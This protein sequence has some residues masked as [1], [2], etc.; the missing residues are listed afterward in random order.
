VGEYA[1]TRNCGQGN[2][3]G[4]LGEAAFMTG[5]ERNSDVVI[6]ASYAPLFVNINYKKWNPDLIDFDGARVYG[7]PSYY[8][9]KMFSENR[10]DVV[11]PA[12]LEV[13]TA[14][15]EAPHGGIGLSTW[16]TQAEFKDMRVT[17]GDNTLFETK[18]GKGFEGWRAL[19]GDWQARDVV[20]QQKDK[21]ADCRAVAGDPGWGDYTYSLKARKL[22]GAEGF[23][24]MFHVL[25]RDNWVWWN[26][27][28]W[29]NVKHALERCEHGNKSISSNEVQGQIETGRWYDIRIEL[30]GQTIKCY[31]DNKLS[32]D[33]SS[34]RTNSMY[35]VASRVDATDEII[36]KV[37]NVSGAAQDTQVELRG[38]KVQPAGTATV[39]TSANP[40]DENSI[41]EPTKVAPVTQPIGSAGATFRHTFPAYSLTI[42]R[43][44]S[45]P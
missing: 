13:E 15:A 33:V 29:G 37:V 32:H 41:A 4:A 2:L 22:G 43:L 7:I 10:G 44:K 31:L 26:L 45:N 9:Q 30:K 17:Q 23:L 21:G 3:R 27:G 28:G 19:C 20:F 35:A 11:L 38:L 18:P 14:P 5:L 1:V 42:L 25:D 16:N 8:V 34:P 40:D 6:M 24:V 12:A 39:L 36:I